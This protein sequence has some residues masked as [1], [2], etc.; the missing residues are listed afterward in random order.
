LQTQPAGVWVDDNW[1]F[2][3][4]GDVGDPGLN[5]GD[6]V[7]ESPG[8]AMHTFG[9]DAFSTI[10]DGVNAVSGGGAVI[11][12]NG[13]YTERVA[14]DKSVTISGQSEPDVFVQADSSAAVDGHDAF[15][16]NA[17]GA[18]ISIN[19]LFIRNSDWG[20]RSVAG[21]VSVTDCTFSNDGFDGS[22]YPI[23]LSAADAA[24]FYAL[25]ATNGGAIAIADSTGIDI[26]SNTI[27]SSD[28]GIVLTRASLAHVHD[29]TV[30]S[31]ARG[32]IKLFDGS[33]NFVDTNPITVN[34]GEGLLISGETGTSAT[35]NTVNNNANAGIVLFNPREISVSNNQVSQNNTR[36]FSGDGS[37]N[38]WPAGIYADG[39]GAAGGA[40]TLHL[41]NNSISSNGA[42]GNSEGSV[43]LY[44]GGSLRGDGTS[45]SGPAASPPSINT[46]T[47]GL[48]S[49][50]SNV[51]ISNLKINK[52]TT[53]MLID[54]GANVSIDNINFDGSSDANSSLTDLRITAAAGFAGRS[55]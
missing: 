9:V 35:G 12:H 6:T 17:P 45:V 52:T 24:A 29:N 18:T 49:S 34:G 54:G 19:H 31:N 39:A 23:G 30:T 41:D 42:G 15:D 44:L 33:N 40:F 22:S 38:Q 2:A 43:G 48:R 36:S 10:Q 46:Q 21:N 16:I 8:G 25:H 26:S 7:Q 51:S 3:P 13:T 50:A 28:Q 55:R 5:F 37:T 11:V 20:I 27:N 47:I 53:A 4:G 14:I 1:S 32:G